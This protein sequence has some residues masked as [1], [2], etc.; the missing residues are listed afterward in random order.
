MA[1]ETKRSAPKRGSAEKA[2]KKFIVYLEEGD[3]PDSGRSA[4][5][6]SDDPDYT[7][8]KADED[9]RKM[10]A[11]IRKGDFELIETK[12]KES[13]ATSYIYGFPRPDGGRDAF[14]TNEPLTKDSYKKFNKNK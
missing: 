1:K 3:R 9:W 13:G 10:L 4:V 7:Q 6:G 14:A 12:K 8:E 11:R 2:E 5:F